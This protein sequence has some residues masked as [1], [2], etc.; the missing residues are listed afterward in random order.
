MMWPLKPLSNVTPKSPVWEQLCSL[1]T[2]AWLAQFGERR[3]AERE[4]VGSNHGRTNTQGLKI[5]EDKLL[6]LQ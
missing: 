5:T 1:L 4:V 2:A 3:S 6:T